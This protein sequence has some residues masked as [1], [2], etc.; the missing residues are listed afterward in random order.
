MG[1]Q[2]CESVKPANLWVLRTPDMFA[3]NWEAYDAR[4]TEAY[5]EK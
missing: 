4:R 2:T 3:L 5:Q 1:T